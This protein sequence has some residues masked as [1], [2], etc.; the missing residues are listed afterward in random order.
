MLLREYPPPGDTV[1]HRDTAARPEGC[2]HRLILCAYFLLSRC[3]GA[4]VL[5]SAAPLII[6]LNLIIEFT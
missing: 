1:A 5:M 2:L 6:F 4:A 3:C